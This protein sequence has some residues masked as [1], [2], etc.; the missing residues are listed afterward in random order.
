MPLVSP[1]VPT[2][3]HH[4]GFTLIELMVSSAIFTMVSV[5]AIGAILTI[6]SA[7]RKAQAIRAVVDNMNFTLESMS[8]KM[9]TGNNYTCGGLP[10][11][12]N[13]APTLSPCPS[14][15]NFISFFSSENIIQG[16]L[17]QPITYEL[18]G[19]PTSCTP[20]TLGCHGTIVTYE[21]TGPITF[22]AIPLT[23]PEINITD[24][25]FFVRATGKPSVLMLVNGVITLTRER[26][27]VPF[28]L[29]TSISQRL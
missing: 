26:I 6:N 19:E 3:S 21:Q 22:V 17:G 12:P 14:G 13:T 10:G 1:H 27:E 15:A 2:S 9:I 24:L 8:R 16:T 28:N 7:N 25:R 20:G 5:V 23:P 29:E 18:Q 11:V 4:C